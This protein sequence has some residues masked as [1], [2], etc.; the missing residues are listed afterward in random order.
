MNINPY[1]FRS[2]DIRGVYEKEILREKIDAFLDQHNRM[3]HSS[4]YVGT[5]LGVLQIKA[6]EIEDFD[7]LVKEADYLM[8]EDKKKRK[9]NRGR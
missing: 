8:Y 2:Y 9:M 6:R 3:E 7:S 1:I 4:C 5:S